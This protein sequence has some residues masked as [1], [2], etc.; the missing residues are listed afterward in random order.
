VN[1]L[2]TDLNKF[3]EKQDIFRVFVF[4]ALSSYLRLLIHKTVEN[5]FKA[6]VTFSVGFSEGRRTVVAFKEACYR[7]PRGVQ[8]MSAPASEARSRG[9]G[10]GKKELTSSERVA[11]WVHEREARRL[12]KERWSGLANVDRPAPDGDGE[13]GGET[14]ASGE[15]CDSK[16]VGNPSRAKPKKQAVALYVPPSMRKTQS[17]KESSSVKVSSNE[18]PVVSKPHEMPSSKEVSGTG[19][20]QIDN[21]RRKGRGRGAKKPEIQIYKPRALRE[22]IDCQSSKPDKTNLQENLS[23]FDDNSHI[24]GKPEN[25]SITEIVNEQSD[26]NRS[27]DS[28]EGFQNHSHS[29]FHYEISDRIDN[30]MEPSHNVSQ[31]EKFFSCAAEMKPSE[32]VD[33]TFEFYDPAVIAFIASPVTVDSGNCTSPHCVQVSSSTREN[34]GFSNSSSSP[35]ETSLDLHQKEVTAKESEAIVTYPSCGTSQSYINSKQNISN[36]HLKDEIDIQNTPEQSI[37]QKDLTKYE[38]DFLTATGSE[39]R[40]KPL[41]T[42]DRSKLPKK[43]EDIPPINIS[44]SVKSDTAQPNVCYLSSLPNENV[45]DSSLDWEELNKDISMTSL[46]SLPDGEK[47]NDIASS[48]SEIAPE[49]KI[50][51]DEIVEESVEI[52][53]YEGKIS[54]VNQMDSQDQCEQN[55]TSHLKPNTNDMCP[56][57]MLSNENNDPKSV[58]T[59]IKEESNDTYLS[60]VVVKKNQTN[61]SSKTV[62]EISHK[63]NTCLS[64]DVTEIKQ[65]NNISSKIDSEISDKENS[66]QLIKHKDKEDEMEFEPKVSN[67]D[68]S[69]FEIERSSNH[70]LHPKIPVN[71]KSE[72]QTSESARHEKFEASSE[73]YVPPF[74]RGENKSYITM[75][76]GKEKVESSLQDSARNTNVS[77][78]RTE[79]IN[80]TISDSDDCGES[81]DDFFDDN[82]DCLDDSIMTELT[83]FVGKVEIEKPTIN[84]LKYQPK[85]IEFDQQAFS[86]IVEI[87]DFPAEL[88]TC[89]IITAFRDFSSRGF[90]VKWVDDTHALGIFSS[91]VAAN[92]ALQ[93]VHPLLKVRPMSKA[94]KKSVSKA[95]S[96][97]E[98]LQPYKSR[99]QTT[100]LAA[101]RLVAGALGMAPRVSREMRDKERQK[102]KDAKDKRREVKQQKIDIWD[103]TI[104][105]K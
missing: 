30:Q 21:S 26:K 60:T 20:A 54:L 18:T 73:K 24:E 47:E 79:H 22:T 75:T 89:D 101:R 38:T 97:Q 51:L 70:D 35:M 27:R 72:I 16:I 39:H 31:K 19:D 93:M 49:K 32:S 98:F 69:K 95:R 87:Y 43:K 33:T 7:G 23:D 86:H 78:K 80:S 90:D 81:W 5:H 12:N 68:V 6:L 88:A 4:P 11:N 105:D 44:S 92:E 1:D 56:L 77:E 2:I 94:S 9:R 3:Y 63:V 82:G 96:N 37:I 67:D 62:S 55:V 74:K 52:K 15:K 41:Y 25:P 34:S 84:Y 46:E 76:K 91:T 58:K 53:E 85:E 99:P 57:I 10:R 71:E 64:T 103:G 61:V 66:F 65:T 100:S 48:L 8:L 59:D 42:W 28:N 83:E 14:V 102:L 13:Q 40:T 29:D 104:C 17:S 36:F 45:E 50:K